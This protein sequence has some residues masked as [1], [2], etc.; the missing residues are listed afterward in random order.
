M[1]AMHTA[2]MLRDTV[3]KTLYNGETRSSCF[4]LKTTQSNFKGTWV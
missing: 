4:I 2:V 1:K 3:K